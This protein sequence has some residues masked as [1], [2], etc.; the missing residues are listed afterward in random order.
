MLKG[1]VGIFQIVLY[2]L[3]EIFEAILR[4]WPGRSGVLFR[5]WYYR[6]RLK[7]V[8]KGVIIKTGVRFTGHRYITLEDGCIVDIGCII[9]A[10]SLGQSQYECRYK[11]NDEFKLSDGEVRIGRK[12][13]LSVGC[14]ILGNGG[15]DIGDFGGLA[16][17]TRV[18]SVT[19][20]YASF[21]DPSRHNVYFTINVPPENACFMYG[22]IVLKE[23]V[24]IATH[25]V[26]LP[27]LTIHRDSFLSMYSIAKGVIESNSIA[28]G[29]PAVR[30]KERF[31]SHNG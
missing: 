2:E 29:N 26:L 27:G 17:G 7:Y 20:H 6:C 30:I 22:P 19:N 11:A 1:V 10:G 5:R 12:V 24:G 18:L 8:G 31:K 3:Q 14:Y 25:C 21:T 15:V 16:A 28:A 13:H 23:N 4:Y 9:L